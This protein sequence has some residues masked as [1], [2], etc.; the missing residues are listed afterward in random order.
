MMAELAKLNATMARNSQLQPQVVASVRAPCQL[1]RL[2]AY[3]TEDIQEIIH[4][5]KP[6]VNG[7]NNVF[8]VDNEGMIVIAAN[9]GQIRYP[10]FSL[11]IEK[12]PFVIMRS[13]T[14]TPPG[15]I[16]AASSEQDYNRQLRL[17][18][19]MESGEQNLKAKNYT[20][21]IDT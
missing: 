12:S 16:N 2:T 8:G 6:A 5:K 3:S 19:M 7:V 15:F 20:T 14:T 9:T 1:P 10:T 13:E 21:A 11:G 17:S 18:Q 4:S